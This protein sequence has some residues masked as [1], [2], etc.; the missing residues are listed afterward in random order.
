M[1]LQELTDAGWKLVPLFGCGHCKRPFTEVG[2]NNGIT[3]KPS[4][5]YH[6]TVPLSN[7]VT[8][9]YQL[10]F[11][12]KYLRVNYPHHHCRP[13]HIVNRQIRVAIPNMALSMTFFYH[14]LQLLANHQIL[15]YKYQFSLLETHCSCHRR[16]TCYKL[17]TKLGYKE[18]FAKTSFRTNL[19]GTVWA[20]EHPQNYGTPNF[21]LQPLNLTTSSLVNN[22]GLGSI[23]GGS[24]LWEHTESSAKEIHNLPSWCTWDTVLQW[25]HEYF[26]K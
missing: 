24:R 9:Y 7:S 22:F 15:N 26:K 4:K 11:T 13:A 12:R 19:A 16:C 8:A 1:A 17:F 18:Q 3:T 21:F 20:T 10:R 23:G 5:L 25:Q 6:Q 2:D 14:L